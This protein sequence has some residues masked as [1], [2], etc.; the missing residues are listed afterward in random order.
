MRVFLSYFLLLT[1]LHA[2]VTIKTVR[3]SGGDYPA[4]LAGFQSAVNSCASASQTDPCIVDAE[5][6]IT[7]IDAVTCY[8]NLP[9]LTNGTKL[10]IIRS[11]RIREL[12]AGTR[13]TPSDT[14]KMAT[15]ENACSGTPGLGAILIQPGSSPSSYYILQGLN[16]YFSGNTRNAL[17][18]IQI[19]VTI[20]GATKAR[21]YAELPKNIIID[22]CWA[23]GQLS[24]SWVFAS[25]SHANQ[26]GM[27][28]NGQNIL[29][30]D[31]RSSDNN[32]DQIDWGQGETH[33]IQIDNGTVISI[34]NTHIDGAIGSLIGG[35]WMWITAN[36]PQT[37]RFFGNYYTRNPYNWHWVDFNTADTLDLTQ[38][39]AENAFW[40][41]AG[42]TTNT[43]VCTGGVWTLTATPRPNRTW[44]KNAWECKNC[45]DVLIEGQVTNLVPS[46]GDQSQ[47][48]FGILINNVDTQESAYYARPEFITA[49]FSRMIQVGQG[50]TFSWGGVTS[51]YERIHDVNINNLTIENFAGPITSPTQ[52]GA[53]GTF[54][55]GGGW[56]LQVSGLSKNLTYKNITS[57][58]GRAFGG[59]GMRLQDDGSLIATNV[60]LQD[61]ILSWG[62]AGQS[63]LNAFNEACSVFRPLM[64]GGVYWNYFGY[65][66]SNS[67]GSSAFSS[68]YGTIPPCPTSVTRAATYAAV[69]FVNYN[70]G[71]DGDYRLCTAAGVPDAGCPGASPYAT[72]SSTGG[73]LGADWTNVNYATSGVSSGTADYE[74][75]NFQIRAATPS[76]IRY[77]SYSSATCDG[78]IKDIDNIEVDSW[79]DAGGTNRDR[80]H[81]PSLAANGEYTVR[82]TCAG[83]WKETTFLRTQ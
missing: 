56:Q 3:S 65:I 48:G 61:N 16:A 54:S 6:N 78:S 71:Q 49:R 5:A 35:T 63:P 60:V 47:Y 36:I 39:C 72:A 24:S 70:S 68:V 29:V 8:L 33:G 37:I 25:N 66:D 10:V 64:Q 51:A 79:T 15:I 20:D 30:K 32:Q 76:V 9:A 74:F 1:S 11:S 43:Y 28:L 45:R 12:P 31:S 42:S 58:Y 41:E 14:A 80:S 57:L 23:H 73:P 17:G 2:A 59:A 52:T 21:T 50:P 18:A 53:G 22:R 75:F 26:Q 34:Y 40:Q 46:V 19:G 67:R 4:T 7:Y 69:N 38:P 55:T 27:L 13:V 83:R 62:T 82:V 44:T 81:T 77:T